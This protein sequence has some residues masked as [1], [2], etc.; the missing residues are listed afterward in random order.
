MGILDLIKHTLT[1][2]DSDDETRDIPDYWRTFLSTVLRIWARP[3][4]TQVQITL[5]IL[6]QFHH[7]IS[8][9]QVDSHCF[10]KSCVS[11]VLSN[12]WRSSGTRLADCD[13]NSRWYETENLLEV[14]YSSTN[15][16]ATLS[17]EW[18][19]SGASVMCRLPRSRHL[20][21]FGTLLGPLPKRPLYL[22][23]DAPHILTVLS[24]L[25]LASD[26]ASALHVTALTSLKAFKSVN[27]HK[28]KCFEKA[29]GMVVRNLPWVPGQVRHALTRVG[30]PELDRLVFASTG[31]CTVETPCNREHPAFAMRW[32]STRSV[33][34]PECADFGVCWL[35]QREN[36]KIEKKEGKRKKISPI[37]VAPQCRLAR[38][39]RRLPYLYGVVF[40]S[41]C[42]F[43]AVWRPR[44]GADPAI[45][46]SQHEATQTG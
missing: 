36:H 30:V 34:T 24:L 42:Y 8:Y 37:W 35:R 41:T 7:H 38:A 44:H 25:P 26:L 40:A 39:S 23:S 20:G 29:L 31:N 28:N 46:M 32:V 4:H 3:T 27:I 15:Y 1:Q 19:C 11:S 14:Q 18:G 16:A 22:S 13:H 45:P 6:P 12:H 33:L 43:C 17:L 5:I 21:T 9:F 2:V 10:F